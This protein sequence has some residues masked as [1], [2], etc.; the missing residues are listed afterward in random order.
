M[1][2]LSAKWKALLGGQGNYCASGGRERWSR[3][4]TTSPNVSSEV[5]SSDLCLVC[6]SRQ[7]EGELFKQGCG[8]NGTTSL[9]S[10]SGSCGTNVS[11][12]LFQAEMLKDPEFAK[13]VKGLEGM[14]RVRERLGKSSRVCV[15]APNSGFHSGRRDAGSA[16]PGSA[17][18][19]IS[20]GCGPP[21]RV[22]FSGS[23]AR[24]FLTF[25]VSALLTVVLTFSLLEL[26]GK[27]VV[28]KVTPSAGVLPCEN[29]SHDHANS[30]LFCDIV[31]GI[32][33]AGHGVSRSAEEHAVVPR[34]G[35]VSHATASECERIIGLRES[36]FSSVSLCHI[37]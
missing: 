32:Q 23:S 5:K 7:R 3:L 22:S 28:F 10:C 19:G 33:D 31:E 8:D 27:S 13:N 25:L 6:N 12:S 2:I 29:E 1:R 17:S 26:Q 15:P 4:S 37:S 18:V 9:S 36:D 14:L 24:A 35:L 20:G 34:S 16:A 21:L 11:L 30:S